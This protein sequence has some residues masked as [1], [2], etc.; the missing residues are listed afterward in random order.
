MLFTDIVGSTSQAAEIGDS[1]WHNLL[2]RHDRIVAG[3]AERFNGRLVKSTGDGALVV[4]DGPGSEIQLIAA[5]A[6][7]LKGVP[8]TWQLYEPK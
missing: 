5:G 1:A 7:Q 8:D 2:D 6:H 4:L 3:E